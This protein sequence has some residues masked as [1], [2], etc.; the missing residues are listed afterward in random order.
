MEHD[1]G[2]TRDEAERRAAQVQ[3]LLGFYDRPDWAKKAH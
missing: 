1:G 2:L 3:G